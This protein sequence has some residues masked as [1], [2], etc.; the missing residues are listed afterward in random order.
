M[1]VE[2]MLETSLMALGE[3]H[4]AFCQQS[5]CPQSAVTLASPSATLMLSR[6]INGLE[7][8]GTIH[9]DFDF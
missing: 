3:I 2:D 5:L 1:Q 6:L 9:L 7:G 8:W 4:R